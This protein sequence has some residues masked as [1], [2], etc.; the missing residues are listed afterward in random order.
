MLNLLLFFAFSL[1][2]AV[3]VLVSRGVAGT[4]GLGQETFVKNG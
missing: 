1:S 4:M 3:A 2:L